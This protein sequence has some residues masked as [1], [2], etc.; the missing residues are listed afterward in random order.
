MPNY[1]RTC[2]PGGTFFFTVNLLERTRNNLLTRHV[3]QLRNSVRIVR[4]THPFEIHGWVVLPD[5]LHCVMRLPAGDTDFALRWRL[6]KARFSKSLPQTER[7]STVRIRRGERGIWQR[8]FW[9]HLICN[10]AD[11]AAHMDYV[12]FNPVKH[13]LVKWVID[14]PYS[15]FHHLVDEG[16]YSR[17]WAGS[18]R[19]E[20]AGYD[21]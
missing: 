2:H 21:D 8:R 6:I 9:E 4:R 19:V 10:E 18:D 1:R 5:H 13:G 12:H 7:R 11:Y 15:T 20:A 3:D 17:D 14:W 16:I